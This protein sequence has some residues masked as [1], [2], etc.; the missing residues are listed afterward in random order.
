M[1]VRAKH[2]SKEYT[3]KGTPYTV[4]QEGSDYIAFE[5]E[6][7]MYIVH[8]AQGRDLIFCQSAFERNFE[9]IKR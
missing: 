3:D 6:N 9:I 7:Y 1:V 8:D 5:K 2:D 4:F